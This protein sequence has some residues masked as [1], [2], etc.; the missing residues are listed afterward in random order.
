MQSFPLE[1][2]ILK[3]KNFGEAD[4]I[5]TLFSKQM[6][7]VSLVAKGIRRINS[8]RAG[9]VELLNRVKV[10]LVQTKGLPILTEAVSIQTFP[11]LKKNLTKVSLAYL[12]V[13]LT[14]KFFPE[15]VENYSLFVLLVKTLTSLEESDGAAKAKQILTA[16]QIKLLN[17]AGY[18]P[19]LYQ[20]ASCSEKLSSETNYFATELGG[21]VN[22][23]CKNGSLMSRPVDKNSVKALRFFKEEGFEK[24]VKLSLPEATND[25]LKEILTLYSE[26]ILEKKL[27]SPSFFAEVEAVG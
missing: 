18:L 16:F 6:G 7:K 24:T 27:N 10:Y 26:F 23:Q 17:L 19:E 11:N 4:R 12:V 14:D 21:I 3:R 13:E 22:Y 20:C 2:I 5:I 9:N 15:E 1:G 8:R 25:R